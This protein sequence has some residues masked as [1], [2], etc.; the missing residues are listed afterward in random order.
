MHIVQLSH[1]ILH[2]LF[3]STSQAVRALFSPQV[4]LTE[5]AERLGSASIVCAVML[6]HM[7]RHKSFSL[8]ASSH[9]VSESGWRERQR[10]K[11]TM[12]C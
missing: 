1:F 10:L 2:V 5:R 8:T 12:V 4:R 3:S 7:V 6:Q 9:L 11:P